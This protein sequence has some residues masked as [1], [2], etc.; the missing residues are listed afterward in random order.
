LGYVDLFIFY[1]LITVFAHCTSCSCSRPR[2]GG[3]TN[4]QVRIRLRLSLD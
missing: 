3:T 1:P 2:A 4:C